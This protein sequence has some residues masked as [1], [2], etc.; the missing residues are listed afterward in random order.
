[1]LQQLYNMASGAYVPGHGAHLM[2]QVYAGPQRL[3]LSSQFTGELSMLRD[4]C[5]TS[6]HEVESSTGILPQGSLFPTLIR[7]FCQCIRLQY[8]SSVIRLKFTGKY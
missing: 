3:S 5:V 6:L 4:A 7:L 8:I 1:M 2:T